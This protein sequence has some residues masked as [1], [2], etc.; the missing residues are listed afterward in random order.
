MLLIG[1]MRALLLCA[2]GLLALS[3]AAMGADAEGCVDLKSIPR[4]E[5]CVIQDCSARKNDSFDPGE[6][7]HAPVDA[8]V[9]NLTYS[10]PESMDLARVKRE[11]EMKIRKAGYLNFGPE[12]SG[13][14]DAA[15]PGGIARKG[16]DWLRWS[17]IS[18]DGMVS[19][20][21]TSAEATLE[22]C[23]QAPAISSLKQ[24]EVVECT[25]KSEDSVAMRT[26]ENGQ[27]SLTGN[28]QTLLFA[29]PVSKPF[30]SVASDLRAG[31]FEILFQD[32]GE[33]TARSGRRW[34]GVANS[35]EGEVGVYAL[36]VVP[37]A[38]VLTAAVPEPAPAAPVPAAAVSAAASG[39]APIQVPDPAPAAAAGFASVAPAQAK[40]E[41]TAP[42]AFPEPA[43]KTE[44]AILASV[45]AP[46][47][48]FVGPKPILR[49][50]IEAT[51]DRIYSVS[52]DVTIH[53]LVDVNE[54]GKVTKAEL[55]GRITKDVL[56]LE[57]AAQDAI[58]HWRFEP[59]RQNGRVVAAVKIPVEMHF[60]GRPWRF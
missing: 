7:L 60:Y 34:M 38:E 16:P 25:S 22:A 40:P 35:Q 46:A 27:T 3:T 42:A 58:S 32:H 17:A 36:T 30:S 45:P 47:A 59:A 55:T 57:S 21:I 50:P 28:V 15:N 56:K 39:P 20:S 13:E 6:A 41:P 33:M 44:A 14:S 1:L 53:L 43:P 2:L 49:V 54:D 29:C 51:H 9:N 19:Y 31:G 48:Q 26:G 4:L 5:G 11:L 24:C 10:C 8:T 18:E 12:K 23:G 37:S 52:G